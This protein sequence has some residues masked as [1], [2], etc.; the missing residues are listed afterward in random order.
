[1]KDKKSEI[2]AKVK[3]I[4]ERDYKGKIY[5]NILTIFNKLTTREKRILLKGL[6]NIC[7][8]VEDKVLVSSND[9]VEVKDQLTENRNAFMSIEESNKLE[10]AKQLVKLKVLIMR[11]LSLLL[12]A[13]IIGL[14][15]IAPKDGYIANAIESVFS[16]IRW[17]T[18]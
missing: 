16:V 14:L 6:I 9:L 15:V 8:V 18:G 4:A 12:A 11:V 17:I 2:I 1:M 7:F 3:E 5:D 10:L 13:I